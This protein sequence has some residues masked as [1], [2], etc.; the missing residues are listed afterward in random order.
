MRRAL[1][2]FA[3]LLL[4]APARAE[5]SLRLASDVVHVPAGEFVRGSDPEDL[6]RAVALCIEVFSE[7]G[8]ELACRED[9]FVDET[10]K[11]PVWLGAY[12]IDRTEVT[13]GAYARCVRAGRCRPA[14]VSEADPRVFGPRL[15][16][17]GVT[18]AEAEA[19]CAFVGGRLPTEAE[20]ERAARGDDGTRTFP[21]GNAYDD[22]LANH[23]RLGEHS[24]GV[25]GYR[26]AAPV[27]SFPDG[28]SPHGLADAA[29][30]VWEWTADRYAPGGY[31]DDS[32]VDPRGAP[33]GGERVVRGG[34]WRTSPLSLRVTHRVPVPET[35]HAPD[36]GFRCAYDPARRGP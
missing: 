27:G 30:N 3:G 14:R 28:R 24:D 22:R 29:G 26:Y 33:T 34:S 25:D 2:P 16:V 15:P 13:H 36:L 8:G 4:L 17:A 32:L 20:W 9:A 10:P 7:H 19:Y 23:G 12:A 1:L 6:R 31:P 35:G 11:R 21:W 5:P 18:F